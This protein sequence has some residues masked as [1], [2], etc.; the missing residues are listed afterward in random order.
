MSDRRRRMLLALA[1]EHQVPIL[2][3]DYD[4]ELRYEGA[5]IAALKTI[6]HA[7]QVVYV[8]TFSKVLFPGLRLGYVVAAPP[9][10]EKIALA[11]WNADVTSNVITQSAVGHLLASG[12]LTRHLRRVRAVYAERLAAMLAALADAMPPGTEWTRPRGG[13][14]VWLTLPV[15]VDADALLQSA[16]DAGIRYSPGDVFCGAGRGRR[17]LALSFA[18]HTPAAIAEG[19]AALGDL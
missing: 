1:D 10:L 4:S 7:G 11:R 2:E 16:L 5:P 8:G 19:V 3:D 17:H 12:A 13:H 18:N 6:D 9:L 14:S 15:E